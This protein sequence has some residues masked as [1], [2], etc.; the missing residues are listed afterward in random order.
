MGGPHQEAGNQRGL[1]LVAQP[2]EHRIGRHALTHEGGDTGNL[3]RR[4]A[5][6][7]HPSIVIAGDGS[8]DVAA[9]RGDLRLEPHVRAWTPRGGTPRREAVCPLH[10]GAADGS[11]GEY[12]G[13]GSGCTDCTQVTHARAPLGSPAVSRWR[14]NRDTRA[15]QPGKDVV[16][17]CR[18]FTV[19]ITIRHE[20]HAD[21]VGLQDHRII[22]GRQQV[23][24]THGPSAIR[25]DLGEDELRIGRTPLIGRSVGCRERRHASAVS[26]HRIVLRT[27]AIADGCVR[28]TV[29]IVVDERNLVTDPCAALTGIQLG[30]EGLHLGLREAQRGGVHRPGEGLVRGIETRV[31]DFDD[32]PA[33]P[34]SYLIGASFL[35]RIGNCHAAVPPHFGIEDRLTLPVDER[36]LDP[37]HTLDGPECRRGSG[38]REAVK[39]MVVITHIPDGAPRG[40]LADGARDTLLDVPVRA[41]SVVADNARR[42]LDDDGGRPIR[43][44]RTG[45]RSLGTVRIGRKRGRHAHG[46]DSEGTSGD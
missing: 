22:E 24:V 19:E 13:V 1:I 9:G 15:G 5:S 16:V 31:N 17:Q 33:S 23:T 39:G 32:A 28:V 38:D 12:R 43:R 34:T 30:R 3:S 20:G 14:V 35:R 18:R 27:I 26:V 45:R 21:R 6:A 41:G 10:R 40:H 8:V 29:R 37:L 11:H 42:K 4:L 44:G 46:R 36:V 7:R 2:R 25:E